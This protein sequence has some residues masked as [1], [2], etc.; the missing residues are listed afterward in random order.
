MSCAG[1]SALIN[2]EPFKSCV[3]DSSGARRQ[4]QGLNP[5]FTATAAGRHELCTLPD[6][7]DLRVY[8]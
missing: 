7:L 4:D 8:Q 5:E 6:P 2:D 3:T 1:E